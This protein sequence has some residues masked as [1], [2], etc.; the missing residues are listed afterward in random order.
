MFVF[1][2]TGIFQFPNLAEFRDTAPLNFH[3]R[4]GCYENNNSDQSECNFGVKKPT[5]TTLAE[6]ES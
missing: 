2:L 6:L 3:A 5:T 1:Y 4:F